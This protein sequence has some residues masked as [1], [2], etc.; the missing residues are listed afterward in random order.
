MKRAK[1]RIAAGPGDFLPIVIGFAL[2]FLSIPALL[3]LL[4]GPQ[5]D[6]S[7]GV[8]GPPVIIVHVA[9]ILLGL[10]FVVLG[11]QLL[12]TPGSL[13]YR[14]AHGRLFRR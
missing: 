2:L 3:M 10:G 6:Q 7:T 9:G 11:V 5:Q 14:L 1:W 12:S 4:F 8:L 13:A